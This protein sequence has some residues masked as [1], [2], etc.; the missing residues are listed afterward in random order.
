ML[1]VKSRNVVYVF[2]VNFSIIFVYS[3]N[4]DAFPEPE[5][6]KPKTDGEEEKEISFNS[7]PSPEGLWQRYFESL[8]KTERI[9]CLLIIRKREEKHGIA[10]F[11]LLFYLV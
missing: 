10:G 2:E 3:S 9:L 5:Y 7:F 6:D 8:F 4:G 11:F 1:Y